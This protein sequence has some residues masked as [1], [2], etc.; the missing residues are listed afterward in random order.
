MYTEG[1]LSLLKLKSQH[2]VS[3]TDQLLFFNNNTLPLAY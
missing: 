2:L 1:R 3:I